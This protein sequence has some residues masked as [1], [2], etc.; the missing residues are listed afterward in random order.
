[1]N[2]VVVPR[3]VQLVLLPLAIVGTYLVLKAAGR[4]LL[5]FVIGVR[6]EQSIA[7][8]RTLM[9]I[10]YDAADEDPWLNAVIVR[11]GGRRRAAAIEQVLRPL[12]P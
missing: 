4:V 2:R 6:R 12:R 1:M 8:M 5:L 11:T 10:R 3:W 9:P 7:A